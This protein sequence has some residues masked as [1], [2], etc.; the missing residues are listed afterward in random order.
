VPSWLFPP[1]RTRSEN[2][3]ERF[4]GWPKP[5][6]NDGSTRSTTRSTAGTSWSGRGSWCAPIVARP[7]STSRPSRTS[8]IT[9]SPS[10]SMNWRRISRTE[11]GDRSRPAEYRPTSALKV[12][13]LTD[14]PVHQPTRGLGKLV[15][16]VQRLVAGELPDR[17]KRSVGWDVPQLVLSG[18][19]QHEGLAG[20]ACSM[21]MFV[22]MSLRLIGSRGRW[23]GQGPVRR[24]GR[25]EPGRFRC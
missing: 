9:A 16:A 11:G 18:S 14:L 2:Y 6:L 3:S 20:F 7:A 5:T 10:S 19:P 22:W 25:P 8:R 12:I 24:L 21:F 15:W 17:R 4:T 23:G 1:S 13:F